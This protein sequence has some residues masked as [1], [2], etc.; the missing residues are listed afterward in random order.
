MKKFT[1][2]VLSLMMM[3][4]MLPTTYAASSDWLNSLKDGASDLWDKAKDKGSEI[5]DTVKEEGPGWV[6]TGKEKAG[7]AIDKA[8]EVISDTQQK[9]SDWNASQPEE[10]WDRTGQMING[11]ASTPAPVTTQPGSETSASPEGNTANTIEDTTSNSSVANQDSDSSD[12][13]AVSG[14]Q[15]PDPVPSE[16][17]GT[18]FYDGQWYRETTGQADVAFRGRTFAK[19]DESYLNL[20]EETK[21][22]IVLDGYLVQPSD[23]HDIQLIQPT[24]AKNDEAPMAE[25]LWQILALLVGTIILACV[26]SILIIEWQSHKKQ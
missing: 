13:D 12:A 2:F 25:R 18:L 3:A 16:L 1:V 15:N 19:T 14:Q 17:S 6:E 24:T 4:L 21:N 20:G 23:E 11:G 8:G 5:V 10:F 26:A 9:I 7:E 22:L